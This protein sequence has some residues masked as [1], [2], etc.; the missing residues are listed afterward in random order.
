MPQEAQFAPV[1]AIVCND[2]NNDGVADLL[3]SG[4]E[5]QTDVITGRYDAS[6]G[7]FLKGNKN[8]TFTAIPYP[9]SGFRL[10]GD[11]KDLALITTPKDR[12]VIAAANN[13]S[14]RVFKINNH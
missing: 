11:V 5:Y 10:K 9:V 1:N 7:C 6:F 12:L 2:I 8:K 14:A 13:D 4:N 3:L